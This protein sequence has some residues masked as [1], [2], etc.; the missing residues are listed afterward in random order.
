[1]V[2]EKNKHIRQKKVICID[3]NQLTYNIHGTLVAKISCKVANELIHQCCQSKLDF[4]NNS[5]QPILEI[6]S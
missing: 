2:C 1:M 4:E 6:S 5:K 3:Q